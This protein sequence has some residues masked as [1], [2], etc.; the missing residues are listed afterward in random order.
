[1]Y[2]EQYVVQT[3]NPLYRIAERFNL[4]TYRQFLP[5]Y[6]QISNPNLIIPR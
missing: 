2:V 5:I 3:G 4:I 6:P 1:M